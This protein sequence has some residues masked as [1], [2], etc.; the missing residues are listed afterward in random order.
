MIAPPRGPA[1]QGGGGGGRRC[2]PFK[3]DDP[4]Y[5]TVYDKVEFTFNDLGVWPAPPRPIGNHRRRRAVGEVRLRV[6]DP[7]PRGVGGART[8]HHQTLGRQCAHRSW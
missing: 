4:S 3:L 1:V 6:L 2:D 7:H 5:L 8:R